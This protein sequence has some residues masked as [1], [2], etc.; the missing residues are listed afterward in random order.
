MKDI[1]GNEVHV[2]SVVVTGRSGGSI[3]LGFGI[4]TSI[5]KKMVTLDRLP[6]TDS[7]YRH[8]VYPGSR[9]YGDDVVVL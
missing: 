6:P 8:C 1:N 4:V 5:G 2:G 9:R 3:S 7:R